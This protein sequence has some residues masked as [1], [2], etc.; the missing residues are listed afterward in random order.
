MKKIVAMIMISVMVTL[1]VAGCGAK[2]PAPEESA[3]AVSEIVFANE[4][5]ASA[6]TENVFQKLIN[7]EIGTAGSSLKAAQIAEEILSFAASREIWAV[8][9]SARKAAF[10]E[11]WESLS[12]EEKGTVNDNFQNLAG[13]VDEAFGDYEAAKGS[14]EDAGVGAEMEELVKSEE[15]QKSWKALCALLAEVE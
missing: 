2:A 11:A 8:E 10:S 4:I 9:E 14:F 3:E 13:L 7:M 6:Y 15:A 1:S 5:S 12:D